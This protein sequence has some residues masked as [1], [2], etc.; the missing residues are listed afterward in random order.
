VATGQHREAG[1]GE[2]NVGTREAI[3]PFEVLWGD[4][5][6]SGLVYYPNVFRYLTQAESA[7]L[8]QAGYTPQAMVAEGFA[9]PRA[10]VE[11]DFR[12]PLWV[13]DMGTCRLWVGRIGTSSVRLDFML[14]KA[15]EREPA[16]TGHVVTVFVDRETMRPIPV[17]PALR[18]ALSVAERCSVDGSPDT[19]DRDECTARSGGQTG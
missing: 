8:L 13:H 1:R 2:G 17:P 3:V 11:V 10:H 12:R 5:D 19:H 4:A 6:P 7:L 9:N 14:T 16:V 15:G 18:Q